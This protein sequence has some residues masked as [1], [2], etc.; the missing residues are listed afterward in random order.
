[1][2]KQLFFVGMAMLAFSCKAQE[3][4]DYTLISGK[5]LN[6]DADKA[7]VYNFSDSSK[8][9]RH[10]LQ[11]GSDGTFKDTLRGGK[12]Y[13][14][15]HYKNSAIHLYLDNGFDLTLNADSKALENTLTFSGKGATENNFFQARIKIS[16]ELKDLEKLNRLEQDTFKSK[17]LSTMTS[18]I[19]RLDATKGVSERFKIEQRKDITYLFRRIMDAYESEHSKLINNPDFK[20]PFDFFNDFAEVD[21]NNEEDYEISPSYRFIVQSHYRQ[22]ATKLM[23]SKNIPFEI[24]YL[25]ACS[26]GKN[27]TIKNKLVGTTIPLIK[28]TENLEEFYKLFMDATTNEQHENQVTEFYEQLKTI[29]KG[30]PSPTFENYENYAGGTTSLDDLKG[31]YVYIDVWATWCGPCKKEIPFLKEIEKKYHDKNITFVSISLD[32]QKDYEKWK[33]MVKEKELGGIQLF[34]DNDFQ[35]DFAKDYSIDAIPKFILIDPS[36]NIVN[37]NAPRPSDP[38]LIELF[39]ELKI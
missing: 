11:I 4:A 20:V 39:N 9:F 3:T 8:R 16:K 31:K 7:I 25:K 24:A 13:F 34:A 29:Q 26:T 10:Q 28:R 27:Q 19:E 17:I 22:Q 32:K 38:R 37:S 36:G 23:E 18:L 1:M 30:S 6:N 12:G 33:A 21:Y 35:S 5:F 14:Q 15:L 2:R